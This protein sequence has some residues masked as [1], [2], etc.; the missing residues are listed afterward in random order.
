LEFKERHKFADDK[1]VI[2]MASK[3]LAKNQDKNILWWNLSFGWRNTKP[4]A[5][6][7]QGTMF[8]S[9]KYTM[10]ISCD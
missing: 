10:H 9:E 1:E 5:F 2:C 4:S 7:L 3:L 8:K 6:Q